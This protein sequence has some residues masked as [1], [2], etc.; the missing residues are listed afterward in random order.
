MS[1]AARRRILR[2]IPFL[3]AASFL[4]PALSAQSPSGPPGVRRFLPPA[5][6]VGE[7]AEDGAP[8][9]YKGDDLYLYIDGGAEIYR[10][11]GFVQVLAQDYKSP[12]GRG[13]SLE[14]FQMASPE[15][16]YGIYTF[17]RGPR[18]TLVPVGAEGQLEDYYLNFW[19]GDLLVTLT[20]RDTDAAT[21]EGLLLLAR[22]VASKIEGSS[23]PPALTAELPPSGLNKTSVRYFKGYLGFMNFY[24]SLAREAFKFEE[25]EMGE[26]S[27]GET[28]FILRYA[29]EESLRQSFP[30]IER[31][32]RD[33]PK[34]RDFLA[35]DSSSFRLVDDRG[36][37]VSLRAEGNL[38][39]ICLGD[40]GAEDRARALLKSVGANR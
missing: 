10:E 7:W 35:L 26:Y 24:P 11:Y 22:A 31:A 32:L 17:K 12:A 23:A 6:E 15:S 21:R 25:G 20:G 14:I 29:S 2:I 19:K 36:K 30:T 39:L 13:L 27:S 9:E 28:L 1:P 5:K 33:Q 38:L 34:A 18:G 37:L 8:Q 3:L 40:A 16:A 4:S